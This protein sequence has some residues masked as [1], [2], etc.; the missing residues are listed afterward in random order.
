MTPPSYIHILNRG[1]GQEF[2]Y[3]NQ[4][5]NQDLKTDS[6]ANLIF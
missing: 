2:F 6:K 4:E 3:E 5:E 1:G